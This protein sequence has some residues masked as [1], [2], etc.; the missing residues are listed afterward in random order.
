MAIAKGAGP[1]SLCL[2][3]LTPS[4]LSGVVNFI[5]PAVPLWSFY[6]VRHVEDANL[7]GD[8]TLPAFGGSFLQ[9]KLLSARDPR[10]IQIVLV[11]VPFQVRAHRIAV[12]SDKWLCKSP[13]HVT[14]VTVSQPP[15]TCMF[16]RNSLRGRGTRDFGVHSGQSLAQ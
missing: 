7:K 5:A 16:L 1:I 2:C 4:L 10:G 15:T 6:K 14:E 13:H 11:S 8:D 9:P 12:R 3:D